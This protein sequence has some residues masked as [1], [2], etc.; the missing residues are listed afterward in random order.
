MYYVRLHADCGS[1]VCMCVDFIHTQGIK[2]KDWFFKQDPYA[3]VTVGSQ[4]YRTRTAIRGGTAPVWNETFKFNVSTPI[5]MTHTHTHT[6]TPGHK[7]VQ[8]THAC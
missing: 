8:R 2:D 4:V 6:H 5:H 3:V 7:P 1:Y